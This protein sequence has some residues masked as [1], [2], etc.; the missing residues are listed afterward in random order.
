[1]HSRCLPHIRLLVQIGFYNFSFFRM[2]VSNAR[3][4]KW[5]HDCKNWSQKVLDRLKPQNQ[6][7]RG[8][9]HISP[10]YILRIFGTCVSVSFSDAASS[11]LLERVMYSFWW[12]SNSSF[13]VCSLVNV[14]RWRRALFSFFFFFAD[15]TVHAEKRILLNL[16]TI[17]ECFIGVRNQNFS[18]KIS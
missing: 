2:P 5:V 16:D 15:E 8:L 13:K 7:E 6:F 4:I 12:N 1:M 18:A 10:Y 9:E 17:S 3:S 11:N 14:V